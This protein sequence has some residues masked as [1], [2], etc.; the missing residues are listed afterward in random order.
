MTLLLK[1]VLAPL[2]VVASSLAGRRWGDRVA[3]MMAALPIVAGPILLITSVEHG[4]SFAAHAASASLLGLVS[5]AVFAVAFAHASRRFGWLPA[6]AVAWTAT[7]AADVVL[8]PWTV[9]PYW[10]LP[11]VLVA[12]VAARILVERL[13]AAPA[14]TAPAVTASAAAA[15][16]VTAPAVTAPVTSPW[17]DLPARAAATAVLVL[18]VTGISA[19][20]GPVVTG[21]LA[22]FPVATSV[23]AAFVLARQGSSA[24]VRTLVGLTRGLPA[25]AAFCFL[26]AVLLGPVGTA[27][28]FAIAVAGALTVQAPALRRP[29][30]QDSAVQPRR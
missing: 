14:V 29:A 27:G 1:L 23:I 19:A 22:P 18:T 7:V 8:A 17:W 30:R 5:L 24:T 9:G 26:L 10:G 12:V 21:I 3:G 4:T 11:I 20:V 2:L 28:A 15:P 16:A 25:F 6:L 13:A